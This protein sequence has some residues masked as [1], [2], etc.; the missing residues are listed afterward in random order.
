MRLSRRESV[1]S[2]KAKARLA[3]AGEAN[4]QLASLL[5]EETGV[6]VWLTMS[7][8]TTPRSLKATIDSGATHSM[9]G[10]ISLFFNLC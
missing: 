2:L 6:E 3:Q 10:E 9:C 8:S 4:A 7:F 5:D 1:S